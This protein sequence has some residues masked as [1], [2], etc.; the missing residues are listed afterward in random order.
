M[1][2]VH[3]LMALVVATMFFSMLSSPPPKIP[4]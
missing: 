1:W 4:K 3:S 2:V